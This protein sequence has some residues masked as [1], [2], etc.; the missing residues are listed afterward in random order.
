MG[1]D[2]YRS[3]GYTGAAGAMPVAAGIMARV[4]PPAAWPVPPNIVICSVDPENGKLANFW[5][6]GGIKVPYISNT[7][8]MDVSDSG[9]DVPVVREIPRVFDY[10]K[11]LF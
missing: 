8:P 4:S 7:Q 6:S 2:K 10:L 1:A 11:N 3:I 5:T 9:P